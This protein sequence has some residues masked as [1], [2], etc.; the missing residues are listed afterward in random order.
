MSYI[1]PIPLEDLPYTPVEL[2]EML[3]ND[4]KERE[5][6]VEGYGKGRLVI[7]KQNKNKP[8]FYADEAN[9][10]ANQKAA[11][12]LQV[13]ETAFNAPLLLSPVLGLAS[14]IPKIAK[15]RTR[16]QIKKARMSAD[17][18]NLEGAINL[19]KTVDGVFNMPSQQVRDIV[20]IAKKNKISYKQAEEYL[21]LKLRG[22]EPKG[23]LNPGSGRN[24]PIVY[25][26]P[27]ERPGNEFKAVIPNYKPVPG[28]DADSGNLPWASTRANISHY[29]VSNHKIF[30]VPGMKNEAQAKRYKNWITTQLINRYKKQQIDPTLNI[31]RWS[32]VHDDFIDN[33]GNAWR[34]V[35][36]DKKR[37]V[38][39]DQEFIPTPLRDI[40]SRLMKKRNT[41]DS[42]KVILHK[43]LQ[44]EVKDRNSLEKK[45]PWLRSW[46]SE[47][48]GE[49]YHEHMYGLDETEFWNSG[50]GKSLGYMNN[51]VYD[52]DKGL[53]NIVF[54]QDPRFKKAKDAVADII[55][56]GKKVEIYPG[57]KRREGAVQ[58]FKAGPYKDLN[59][60]IGYDAD[61][62]SRT[63][64]DLTIVAYNPDPN[65]VFAER[66]T[67]IPNYYSLVFAKSKGRRL[68]DDATAKGFLKQYVEAV[69][70]NDQPKIILLTDFAEALPQLYPELLQPGFREI[71]P[72]REFEIPEP[73]GLNLDPDF[74]SVG[75]YSKK[76]PDPDP[77]QEKVFKMDNALQ[78]KRDAYMKRLLIKLKKGTYTQL[79][80]I[81]LLFYR[82]P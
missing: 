73:S 14:G 71:P 46:I 69:L 50:Y 67:T 18:S 58:T 77:L 12:Q 65:V 5:I 3:E 53:G 68:I 22:T 75:K 41:S 31:K 37:G 57:Y 10:P 6:E 70:N 72:E 23:T 36:A 45:Y 16:A 81:N 33:K 21:N 19:K 61:P 51:D 74:R 80:F 8:F 63:Y 79:D 28:P 24:D 54:L 43:L 52:L 76:D 13:A 39:A 60:I 82:D 56:P 11:K 44:T 62:K 42:E 4:E 17:E 2:G 55:T 20:R 29:D 25:I 78:R 26:P 15:D 30:E 34:L 47:Q 1:K 7:S 64:T 66:V 9:I 59:A 35:K 49:N 40:D 38:G 32:S 48:T 27:E